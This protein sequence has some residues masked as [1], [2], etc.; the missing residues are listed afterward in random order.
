MRLTSGGRRLDELLHGGFLPASHTLLYGAPFLGKETFARQF[1]LANLR[2][3]R[4]AIFLLTNDAVSNVRAALLRADAAYP[5]YEANGLVR[6][7]DAY[8]RTL[9]LPEDEPHTEYVDGPLNFN[10]MSVAVN[11]AVKAVAIAQEHHAFIIDSVSTMV[12]MTNVQTTFR[13]LQVLAGKTRMAG[14][15]GLLLMDQGMHSEAD[16]QAFK[17]LVAGV[18]ELKSES[19][20]PALHATGNGI[21][22]D[23]GWVEYRHDADVFEVTGSFAAGRIR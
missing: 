16:V 15:T 14:A 3:G 23:R 20:K 13:F 1:A 2:E 7:I 12:A 22:E 9:G 19:G 11:N 17:H 6:F 8:S 5:T 10:A 21:P 18:I 4:P